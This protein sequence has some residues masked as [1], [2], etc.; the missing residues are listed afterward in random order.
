[1]PQGYDL[2]VTTERRLSCLFTGKVTASA[3][4]PSANVICQSVDH[5]RGGTGQVST[6]LATTQDLAKMTSD[7]A[8]P[9]G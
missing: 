6:W 1:M 4:N 8:A 2:E 9:S 7:P 3:V 5:G